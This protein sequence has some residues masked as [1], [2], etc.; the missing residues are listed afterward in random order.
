MIGVDSQML[1]QT[2]MDGGLLNIT[3]MH[4]NGATHGALQLLHN[5][6]HTTAFALIY[7]VIPC[8]T[9]YGITYMVRSVFF[10]K[11]TTSCQDTTTQV[12]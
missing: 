12:R 1:G 8:F 11:G 4:E 5:Q 10:F 6:M 2:V 9:S 3:G 7:T